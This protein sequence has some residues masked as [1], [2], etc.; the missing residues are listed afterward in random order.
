MK[1]ESLKHADVRGNELY[2]LRIKNNKGN[3]LL[4]NVGVKTA[5]TVK[6]LIEEENQPEL[7]LKENEKTLEIVQGKGLVPKAKK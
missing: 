5:T 4:I 6:N 2:Y 1:I 3:E 7:P